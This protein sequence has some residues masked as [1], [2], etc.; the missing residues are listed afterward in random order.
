MKSIFSVFC[1]GVTS[2]AYLAVAVLSPSGFAETSVSRVG[3]QKRVQ[4]LQSFQNVYESK[5]YENFA[6]ELFSGAT[7]KDRSFFVDMLQQDKMSRGHFAFPE[8][9]IEGN[10]ISMSQGEQ[11]AKLEVVDESK[12]EYKL[13]GIPYYFNSKMGLKYNLIL[14]KKHLES[15]GAV[16]QNSLWEVLFPSAQASMGIWSWLMIGGVVALAG[17]GIGKIVKNSKKKQ[18]EHFVAEHGGGYH[19][20][21]YRGDTHEAMEHRNRQVDDYREDMREREQDIQKRLDEV[22]PDIVERVS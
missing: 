12:G 13:N 8:M 3:V 20:M 5:N 11:I 19:Q 1:S 21:P 4:H 17:W 6:K 18:Q 10:V 2:L 22:E 15:T 16:S 7:E 14:V 9:K